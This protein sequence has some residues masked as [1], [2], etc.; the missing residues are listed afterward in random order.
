MSY[1]IKLGFSPCPNDTFIFDA[2]INK[3][4]DTEGIDFICD[5]E[6]IEQLNLRAMDEDLDMTKVSFHTFLHIAD[7]YQLL[8]AG[9]SLSTNCGPLLIAKNKFSE[10]EIDNLSIAIPGK[11]TTAALLLNYVYPNAK[12]HHEI[13]FSKIEKMILKDIVNAGV[14]I[15]ETR[16]T[17]Q[18]KGLI[19]IC[20]LGCCWEQKTGFPIPLGGIVIRRDMPEELK[21]KLNRILKNS[22]EFAFQNPDSSKEFIKEHSVEIEDEIIKKHIELYVNHYTKSLYGKGEEAVKYLFEYGFSQR[23]INRIPDNIFYLK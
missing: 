6:D 19:K 15:H 22:V 1:I 12:N 23:I 10:P 13:I 4:I 9:S 2:L 11:Y 7:K 14:I 17:Y 18:D 5:A 16:F 21:S 8:D 20:D 3:K